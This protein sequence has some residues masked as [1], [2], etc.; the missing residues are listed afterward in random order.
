M[1]SHPLPPGPTGIPGTAP[2]WDDGSDPRLPAL[3]GPVRADL[4]V[5]G[6]GGSGL[7]AIHEALALGHRVVG[8]DAG[9]VGSGA[10]GRNG[11]FLLA[12]TA[13]FH[14]RA[15]A[16]LGI[17]RATALYRLTLEEI[18]RFHAE[19]PHAVRLTGSLRIADSPEEAAD[20]ESQYA[21]MRRDDLPVER[22]EGSEGSGL[23]FPR[24]GAFQPLTRC[25]LRARQAIATGAALFEHSQV[26]AVERHLVRTR[27]G[28]VHAGQVIVAVDGSVT[29]LL[30]EVSG[31]VR[32]ARL[33]MLATA[34]TPER[35]F[36][37][38][39]Y[40]RWGYDYW[41]QL[42]GGTV[43][44]GGRRDEFE[45]DEWTTTTRPTVPVQERLDRLLRERLGVSAPV[46]HRWAGVV[47]YTSSVLPVV[48]EVRDGVWVA[49]GYNGTGNLVGALC[50][51][52][53]ARLAL[54]GD[55]ALLDPFLSSV[56]QPS[57]ADA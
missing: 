31:R 38:P 32:S 48:E 10:A 29:A 7:A 11:G 26:L 54:A 5:I 28:T 9:T 19:T 37:R 50:G 41:Q 47:G 21:A 34:P 13:A 1:P 12:G 17:A 14:H 4:C 39:V 49:A 30:P 56:S 25:R 43:V 24:D 55:R 53:L 23:L 20:C 16:A 2:V 45:E 18:T 44:L 57:R 22:Y 33:Q 52:G 51:R 8:L 40:T 46:T 3:A 27:E 15:A 6:L 36:P 35:R 42:P